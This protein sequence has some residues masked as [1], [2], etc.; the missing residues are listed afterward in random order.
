MKKMIDSDTEVSTNCSTCASQTTEQLLV[1][2]FTHSFV[3]DDIICE[4]INGVVILTDK[5]QI[6]YSN[7]YGKRIL[8]QLNQLAGNSAQVP[9][10]LWHICQ[11]LIDIRS[12]FPNQFWLAQFDIFIENL[13]NLHINARWLS[14]NQSDQPY[15]LLSIEDRKNTLDK[16]ICQEADQYGLT[17]REKEVWLLHRQGQ[18]YKQIALELQITPN[19]VK[20][21]MKSIHSKRKK[22][23]FSTDIGC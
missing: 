4:L 2:E 18:T 3:K 23:M 9:P 16:I 5:K 15:L 12:L 19:T 10:E 6:V 11:S 20:K 21:H 1:K 17:P 8:K 7:S 13:A 22:A 14:T